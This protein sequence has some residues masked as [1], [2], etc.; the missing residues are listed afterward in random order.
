M[1]GFTRA[2]AAGEQRGVLILLDSYES[3]TAVSLR[4]PRAL[5]AERVVV[6]LVH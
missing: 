6:T 4:R 5:R 1:S 3:M 2:Q